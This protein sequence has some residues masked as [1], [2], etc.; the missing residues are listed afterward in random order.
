MGGEWRG[1]R[2]AA[3]AV[4][5]SP[6]GGVANLHLLE[7]TGLWNICSRP[8]WQQRTHNSETDPESVHLTRFQVETSDPSL[9]S[10]SRPGAAART[11]CRTPR[12]SAST[13]VVPSGPPA[14]I[15]LQNPKLR[16]ACNIRGQECIGFCSGL[17]NHG[18]SASS[19]AAGG[20]QRADSVQTVCFP[21]SSLHICLLTAACWAPRIATS[22]RWCVP[23]DRKAQSR[24][25]GPGRVH[26]CHQYRVLQQCH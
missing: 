19:A 20:G 22:Q 2:A 15:L 16:R 13:I 18:A 17:G 26:R 1:R 25:N 21:H 3:V 11:A 9:H 7:N 4:V 23:P 14:A 6:A 5:S 10:Y 8:A 24:H 12:A